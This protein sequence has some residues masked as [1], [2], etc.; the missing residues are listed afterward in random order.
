MQHVSDEELKR[1][2]LGWQCRIRQMAMRQHGGRPSSG[3]AP[4]ALD[5]KG[6]VLID[7]LIVLLIPKE[8]EDL[9]KF[10]QFQIQKSPDP[11][12]SY[13]AALKLLQSDYFRE[14]KSFSDQLAAQFSPQSAVA[15]LLVEM[16]ECILEFEQ[17]SQVWKLTCQ[18]RKL[19]LD[20]I[21]R[22]H[23]L[24]HN[25]IFNRNIPSDATVLSFAPQWH[26]ANAD[27]A[28]QIRQ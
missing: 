15:D 25:R 26:S 1:Q 19:G 8:P 12:Q 28:P 24:A 14:S 2:F 21:A 10:F 16:G 4:K 27:P 9:T 18:T 5:K 22:Q 11:K 13:E 17:Y 20:D 7:A 3:M 23:V 6:A